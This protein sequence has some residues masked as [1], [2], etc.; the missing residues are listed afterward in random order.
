MDSSYERRTQEIGPIPLPVNT[1]LLFVNVSTESPDIIQQSFFFGVISVDMET[2]RD[3]ETK[4]SY[5]LNILLGKIPIKDRKRI[6]VKWQTL[7]K[8]V[9]DTRIFQCGQLI[10]RKN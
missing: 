4:E 2:G 8:A 5:M 1:S 3:Q 10:L 7:G 9:E 6:E